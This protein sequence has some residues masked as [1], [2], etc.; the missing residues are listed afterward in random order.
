MKTKVDNELKHFEANMLDGDSIDDCGGA[1]I[2]AKENFEYVQEVL[3]DQREEIWEVVEKK[4]WKA[5]E[6]VSVKWRQ[7]NIFRNEVWRAIKAIE[8]YENKQSKK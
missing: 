1:M 4:F 2:S 7:G 6:E 3:Q 5:F 8:N